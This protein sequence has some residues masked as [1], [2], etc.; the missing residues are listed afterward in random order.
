MLY[1]IAYGAKISVKETSFSYMLQFT[2][3]AMVYYGQSNSSSISLSLTNSFPNPHLFRGKP[4]CSRFIKKQ[5]NIRH[6]MRLILDPDD[7]KAIACTPRVDLI[8]SAAVRDLFHLERNS[9]RPIPHRENREL[10]QM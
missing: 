4:S 2:P 3:Y 5:F 10:H 7:S 6:T 1:K 9:A 8:P